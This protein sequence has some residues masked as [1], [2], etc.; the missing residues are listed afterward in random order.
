[1]LIKCPEC[2]K[3]VSDTCEFCIH[4]GFR[5]KPVETPNPPPE[6]EIEIPVIPVIP[7]VENP[8]PP[9]P[10]Q[11]KPS[12]APEPS[13]DIAVIGYRGPCGG[14]TKFFTFVS[15]VVGLNMLLFS[16]Y[17]FFAM[18]GLIGRNGQIPYLGMIIPS[19]ILSA[20]GG[21]L[22][23]LAFRSW[24][25]MRL[26][27]DAKKPLMY[28]R[29]NDDFVT[30]VAIT[31]KEVRIDPKRLVS[32]IRGVSSE[33]IVIAVYIGKNGGQYRLPLGWTSD[34]PEMCRKVQEIKSFSE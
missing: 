3:D 22:M 32:V 6:P 25:R 33:Y 13:G 7:E 19:F 2:G 28:V 23:F 14:G 5:L 27:G 11:P 34:F 20:L 15:F 30:L 1:M 12:I 10:E 26:N 31:G 24:H 9:K 8:T 16:V 21:L 18:L 17:L 4:C 29:E